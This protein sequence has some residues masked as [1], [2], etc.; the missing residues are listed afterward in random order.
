MCTSLETSAT[1]DGDHYVI[2]GQ[3][4]WTSRAEHSDYMI[5]LARTQPKS[6]DPKER[7]KA[8]SVFL[9]DMREALKDVCQH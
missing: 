8:L 1:L 3:K 4:M 2:N 9:V 6:D 5:L 7:R